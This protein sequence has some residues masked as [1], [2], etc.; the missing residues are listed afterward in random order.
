M[1]F[2]KQL[3]WQRFWAIALKEWIQMK[4]DRLTFAMIIGIPLIQLIFFGYAINYNPKHL[5]T[6]V[7]QADQSDITRKI[8]IG[9]Q[10]SDYF[11]ILPGLY[12]QTSANKMLARG[13]VQFVVYFP[14]DFTERLIR[15]QQPELLIEADATDPAATSFALDVIPNLSALID[16]SFT[17]SLS[18]LQQ[19]P[20]PI[21]FVVHTKY[22]PEHLTQFNIVPGLLGVVLTMT[23]VLI[24][25][26][27]MARE[28]ERGTM[29]N[30]LAMPTRPLEVILGKV[31]PYVAVG[32]VQVSLILLA[33]Y[34]LFQIP[35]EGS[36][37]L[38]YIAFLPFIAANLTVGLLFSTV[39]KN[40]LQAMQMA[41]FFFLPSIIL[42]GF[43]FPFRGMPVWAQYLGDLLPLTHFLPIVRGI[44]LKGNGLIDIWPDLGVI[45]LF[46]L[47]VLG[48]GLKRYR[49][50]LD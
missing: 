16:T 20:S 10:N 27:A 43:L 31:L 35:M 15:N 44:L 9:L 48:L 38:L 25:S 37:W 17:G 1:N 24:T 3:S 29:E 21:N 19:A 47:V 2:F 26:M 23:M 39:A 4:R 5:P 7:V 6:V 28:R 33:G 34:F 36:L 50:T 18:Y 12:N 14:P 46:F 11:S 30:L 42:S 45:I 49:Q 8:T 13:E 32:Y 40:Q 22:N 41:F